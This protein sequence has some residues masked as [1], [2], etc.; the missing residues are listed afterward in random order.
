MDH[1]Y[2][3]GASTLNL[4]AYTDWMQDEGTT[5]DIYSEADANF[6]DP[7]RVS[8]LGLIWRALDVFSHSTTS[9]SVPPQ[10]RRHVN[11]HLISA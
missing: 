7:P 8:F 10:A 5:M 1:R 9:L 4:K 6:R 3:A 2:L 11:E